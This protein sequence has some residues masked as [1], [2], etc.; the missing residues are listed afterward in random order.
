MRA[1]HPAPVVVGVDGSRCALDAVDWAAAEAA[2]RSLP[3][4]VVH[5]YPW[6][7]PTDA[8][9]AAGGTGDCGHRAAAQLVLDEAVDRA[10]SV[11]PDG[12]V[13]PRLVL[14]AAAR[15]LLAQT[16]HA[17]L[18]VLGHRGCGRLRGLLGRSVGVQVVAHARCPV[19]VVHPFHTVAPGHS[20]ARVVVGVDG[21]ARSTGAVGY[22]FRAA[23]QRGIGL[24]AVHA[25]NPR[26]PADLEGAVDDL[27]MGEETGRRVLDDA[28]GAWAARFP[29]VAVEP[30]LVRGPPAGAL[31]LESAGAA[32][33][34]VGSRGR[35]GVRGTLLGSVSQ[36]LLRHTH[37]PVAV[38]RG[39]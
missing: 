10:R 31:I 17:D 2:T 28:V 36:M 37:S 35:G 33:T 20:A 11:A 8:F 39:G 6:P 32:L 38:L 4:L 19:A 22:A 12:N 25:W 16:Q 30:K 1:A 3:L 14:G 9:G 34:V 29:G 21:S 18:V 23:A 15:A 5:A 27:G 24:T 26:G 13:S 7:P